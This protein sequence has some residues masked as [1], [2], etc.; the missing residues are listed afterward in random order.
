MSE[1]LFHLHGVS[2]AYG[3]RQVLSGLDFTLEPGERVALLGGNGVG[4]STLLHLLV[5]LHL[6]HAGTLAA[7]GKDRRA[8]EDF[9]EVRTKAGLLFQ[10]PDD[11]L[12][13]PSVLED[14]AFGPL[15]LGK[16]RHNYYATHS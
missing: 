5:G 1:P 10:D 11:Q 3:D 6:P 2:F 9:F 7:F 12:F 13:C 16:S 4:K 15:N 8:E 14:V